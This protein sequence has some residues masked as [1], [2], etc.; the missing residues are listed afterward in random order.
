MSWNREIPLLSLEAMM[1]SRIFQVRLL[2]L[3]V[4]TA[5]PC[6]VAAQSTNA[7][8]T[9]NHAYQSNNSGAP[10]PSTG[11]Q[12]NNPTSNAALLS[13]T[14][15]PALN[16][17]GL[18]AIDPDYMPRFSYGYDTNLGLDSSNVDGSSMLLT[19]SPYIAVQS[20]FGHTQFLIQYDPTFTKYTSDEFSGGSLQRA[21]ARFIGALG[22]RVKWN[23]GSTFA[24]GQ[25]SLRLAAPTASLAIGD[26]AGVDP[27]GAEYQPDAGVGT[28]LSV[29]AGATYL[30]SERDSIDVELG[31]SYSRFTGIPGDS[32]TL[33][34]R[35]NYTRK[36]SPT[37]SIGP[38]AQIL[39]STGSV[40]CASLG[41]G[42]G[43]TWQ[44]AER[45]TLSASGGPQFSSKACGSQE[46]YLYNAAFNTRINDSSQMYLLAGR[47]FNS[48]Y[49]SPGQWQ[50]NV[51][52]G[53]QRVFAHT[54]AVTFD[55]SYAR[56][57]G[58]GTARTYNGV[59]VG[60][61]VGRTIWRALNPSIT[62]RRLTSHTGT[63]KLD[64]TTVVFSLSWN[65]LSSPIFN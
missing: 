42:A 44:F 17:A 39:A 15:I 43:I 29:A 30:K 26:I 57:T 9:G 11:M 16:R 41:G 8:A 58:V 37:L 48:P 53:Y 23:V 22:P 47:Q 56:S 18:L 21:S 28:F 62:Y 55:V 19:A 64:R 50:D 13:P 63:D 45:T 27:S 24:Y 65:S 3:L 54:T 46:S 35:A 60:G 12:D 33:S 36:L 40:S 59:F 10:D 51:G 6:V 20:S 38:Y 34:A 49:L 4:A 1:T 31:D 5:A 61:E 7:S 52:I 14:L 32:S 2:A 25:D